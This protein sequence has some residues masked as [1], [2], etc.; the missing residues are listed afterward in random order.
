MSSEVYVYWYCMLS[1]DEEDESGSCSF[2]PRDRGGAMIYDL[3]SV[4]TRWAGESLEQGG[5]GGGGGGGVELSWRG[6][7]Q[8][9]S[10]LK[11]CVK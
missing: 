2:I 1:C 3:S 8:F 9:T 10:L 5:G 7:E 11:L 6:G 4:G